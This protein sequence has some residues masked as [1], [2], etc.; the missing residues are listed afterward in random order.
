MGYKLSEI[1]SREI[2]W[3]KRYQRAE[4]TKNI[5]IEAVKEHQQENIL[6]YKLSKSRINEKYWDL[7]C[8]RAEERKNIGI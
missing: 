5:G 3:D 7:S 4:E 2:F 8:Q 1:I 6:G